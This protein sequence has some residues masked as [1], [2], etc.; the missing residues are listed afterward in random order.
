VVH[1]GGFRTGFS[2]TIERYLHHD[3]TI[4]VLTTPWLGMAG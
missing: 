4:I 3:L 1:G 2:S